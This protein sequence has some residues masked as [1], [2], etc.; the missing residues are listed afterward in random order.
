MSS[1]DLKASDSISKGVGKLI[2]EIN[3]CE[4]KN[5]DFVIPNNE[6]YLYVSLLNKIKEMVPDRSRWD[7]DGAAV[8]KDCPF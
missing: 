5:K 8:S 6:L 1:C 2:N 7:W 4:I 3:L